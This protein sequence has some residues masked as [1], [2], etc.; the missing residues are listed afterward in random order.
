MAD[1]PLDAQGIDS[2]EATLCQCSES[3]IVA[4]LSGAGAWG[5]QPAQGGYAAVFS[6]DTVHSFVQ[7]R[8]RSVVTTARRLRVSTSNRR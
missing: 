4:P 3:Y 2:P 6:T 5:E 7:L 8:R 1:Y